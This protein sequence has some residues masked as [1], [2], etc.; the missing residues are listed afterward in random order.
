[1]SASPANADGLDPDTA[2][3]TE[4]IVKHAVCDNLAKG[5]SAHDI[6]KLMVSDGFV[7][8]SGDAYKLI[9]RAS[10]RWCPQ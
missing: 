6:A 4:Y 9:T 10:A 1:M 7:Y 2:N 8:N 5:V 3:I